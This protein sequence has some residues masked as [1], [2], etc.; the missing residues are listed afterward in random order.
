MNDKELII[1]VAK[2]ANVDGYYTDG[3]F[4]GIIGC[5]IGDADIPWNPLKNNGQAFLLMVSFL[6][7][8]EV[9]YSPED[10]EYCNYDGAAATRRAIVKAVINGN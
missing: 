7:F 5:E 1:A 4:P 2:I 6:P 9:R 8:W 3:W 10:Y